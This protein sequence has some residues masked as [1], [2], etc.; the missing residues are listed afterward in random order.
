MTPQDP[1]YAMYLQLMGSGRDTTATPVN[2]LWDDQQMSSIV[3]DVDLGY[4][5]F[6]KCFDVTNPAK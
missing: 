5:A 4:L 1:I 3:R 2:D 6:W